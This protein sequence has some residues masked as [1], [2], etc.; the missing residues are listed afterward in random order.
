MN[1]LE[2]N[3][4]AQNPI[5][6][7]LIIIGLIA[8]IV[9][10]ILLLSATVGYKIQISNNQVPKGVDVTLTYTI[11]NG[12]LFDSMDNIVYNYR[13]INS[14]NVIISENNVS[15]GSI[16]ARSTYQN[17]TIFHTSVLD[18]GEYTI[19]TWI[20]YTIGKG[21]VGVGNME[22]KYLSLKFIVY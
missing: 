22:A 19:S 14:N 13:L 15:I 6:N 21:G 18:K 20:V 7:S 5:I 1:K 9:F 8:L 10:V 3:Y 4:K 12:N 11:D 2:T 17:N 16:G